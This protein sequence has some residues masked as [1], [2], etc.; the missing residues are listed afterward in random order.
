MGASSFV[1]RR[2]RAMQ[3]AAEL[4]VDLEIDQER[5]VD[6]FEVIEQLGMWLVFQPLKNLLGA[7]IPH[8]N[9]G[10]MITTEREPAIQRYTAAHEIGHWA[11]DISRTA[12]DTESDVLFVGASERERL[13]QMFASYFLMPP[14]LVHA[15]VSYHRHPGERITPALAYLVA[16]DM[17]VS[18]EAAIRQMANVDLLTDQQRD[19]LLAVKRMQAKQD[20]AFGHRPLDGMADIWLFDGQS[21]TNEDVEVVVNDEIVI[22]LPENRTTGYRWLDDAAMTR[23]STRQARPAPRAFGWAGPSAP[24]GMPRPPSP[25]TAADTLAALSLLPKASTLA[26]G[27]TSDTPRA[28]ATDAPTPGDAPSTGELRVVLDA[29]QP[30]WARILP[31]DPAPLRRHIA[32][33]A[34]DPDTLV[35]PPT[36]PEPVA[37]HRAPIRRP[38]PA[39]PGAGATGRRLL[40]IQASAEGRFR[41]ALHYAP[42]HDPQTA[43]VA[44]YTMQ[45][46]VAAPPMV[47]RRRALLDIDLDDDAEPPLDEPPN[48]GG[49]EETPR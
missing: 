5:P 3:A 30:G 46:A 45:V 18:Y 34:A 22:A 42:V 6:V 1:A 14:P 23:K 17:R 41:F 13:A 24:V 7:V 31:R 33:G 35:G 25:R 11:L 8:G 49:S 39:N 20:L 9:G 2:R 37:D 38:D 19:D 36:D 48:V 43:P 44:S 29:Y 40:A 32:G 4:L 10:V 47:Q 16:R 15:T 12:F 27:G 21:A 28:A 26:A